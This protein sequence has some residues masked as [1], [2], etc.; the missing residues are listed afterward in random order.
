[1]IDL[2]KYTSTSKKKTKKTF[3][4]IFG[5]DYFVTISYDKFLSPRKFYIRRNNSKF[6]SIETG[7][8]VIAHLLP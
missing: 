1:M 3:F 6:D 4:L 7:R 5:A 2:E 8:R